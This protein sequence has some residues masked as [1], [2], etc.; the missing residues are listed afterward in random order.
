MNWKGKKVILT[1][2]SSGIGKATLQCLVK[3]E[4][5]VVFCGK[6]KELVNE[7]SQKYKVI[8]V[9]ADLS[10][11]EE[12]VRF[13]ELAIDHLGDVDILINNAGFVV[14]EDI[15]NL[16][17]SDFELMYAINVIA[18]ARLVQLCLPYFRKKGKGDIVNIGATGGSYGFAK[19]AAYAS[20]KAA[21]A[22]LSQTLVK[23]LR[24]D[25]IR[26]FHLDPS[27]TTGTNNN[28]RGGEIPLDQEKL[29]AVDVAETVMMILS[30]NSRAFIPQISIWETN[31]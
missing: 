22:N 13:F 5:E 7:I 23:E 16:L 21:L 2:A 29:T 31:P 3:Q 12:L 30:T 15:E 24:K 27:W 11:E 19:G 8:G 4:A 25:N 26:V 10:I 9:T 1:G 6:E 17:R 14:V 20:S 28:N 18:P